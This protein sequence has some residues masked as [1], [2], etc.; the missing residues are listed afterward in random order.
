MPRACPKSSRTRREPPDPRLASRCRRRPE[1][2]STG[3]RRR[4]AGL[5]RAGAAVR[6]GPP[7]PPRAGTPRCS[8]PAST[9]Q[10]RSWRLHPVTT[11]TG[12]AAGV[13]V[14]GGMLLAVNVT[15][16]T[17]SPAQVAAQPVAVQPATSSIVT[18]RSTGHR[19]GQGGG[20]GSP[21]GTGSPAGSLNAAPA[22]PVYSNL[23]GGTAFTA[24]VGSPSASTQ[25]GG[26]V[27]SQ[28]T[29]SATSPSRP[30]SAVA[31][32]VPAARQ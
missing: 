32:N 31:A 24:A 15:P 29:V 5:R 2:P 4:P 25:V 23:P 10:W 28:G 18:S 12:A 6:A 13:A 26:S 1:R 19:C 3:R 17:G 20:G 27:T 8:A 11:A 21:A 7:R 16:F 9:G 22:G 14:A 30:A